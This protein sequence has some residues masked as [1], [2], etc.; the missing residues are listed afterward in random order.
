MENEEVKKRDTM[1]VRGRRYQDDR[2][3]NRS[4]EISIQRN[5]KGEE[6][7]KVRARWKNIFD[8]YG[9]EDG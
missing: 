4:G 6:E 8:K 1:Q 7:G 2:K 3:K 5:K 9:I